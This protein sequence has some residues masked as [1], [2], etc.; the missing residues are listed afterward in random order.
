MR[1]LIKLGVCAGLALVP[2]GFGSGAAMAAPTVTVQL[3]Q[4]TLHYGVKS[5][6]IRNTPFS[7]FG[8]VGNLPWNNVQ[9]CVQLNGSGLHLNWMEGTGYV[10]NHT[11]VA[12][13]WL[14]GPSIN[15]RTP[16]YILDPGWE[17]VAWWSPNR[18]VRAGIYCATTE[19]PAGGSYGTACETVHP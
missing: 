19:S 7:A 6:G 13:E 1:K 2:L 12:N 14:H 4:G 15:Y 5:P 8:C 10:R 17:I 18:N 3:P 11:I 16:S 9:T